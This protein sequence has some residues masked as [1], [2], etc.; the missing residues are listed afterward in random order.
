MNVSPDDLVKIIGMKDVQIYVLQQQLA[1]VQQE[2]EQLKKA[3]NGTAEKQ[4]VVEESTF[5]G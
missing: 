2:L 5:K 3:T 4:P 1:I